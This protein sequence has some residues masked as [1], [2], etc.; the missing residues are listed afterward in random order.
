MCVCVCV[1]ADRHGSAFFHAVPFLS[2]DLGVLT[3]ALLSMCPSHVGRHP[4]PAFCAHPRNGAR[5]YGAGTSSP[6]SRRQPGQAPELL[7]G[8]LGPVHF[9]TVP[10]KHVPASGAAH[11]L[12]DISE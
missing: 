1:C 9:H 6:P 4:G 10:G 11:G 3:E 5:G 8:S 2:Q 12:D 7:V